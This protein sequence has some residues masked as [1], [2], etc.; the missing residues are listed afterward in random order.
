M[1][2]ALVSCSRTKTMNVSPVEAKKALLRHQFAVVSESSNW[3]RQQ[4]HIAPPLWMVDVMTCTPTLIRALCLPSGPNDPQGTR[5]GVP[6]IYSRL[7][8][9][10]THSLLELFEPLD[11]EPK[12]S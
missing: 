4:P 2:G 10:L 6:L 1:K 5:R 11:G 7:A 3:N 12:L 9:N 8:Y